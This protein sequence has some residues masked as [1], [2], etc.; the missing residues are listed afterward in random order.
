MITVSLSR[1]LWCLF[2]HPPSHP[3]GGHFHPHFTQGLRPYRGRD[4]ETRESW[5]AP[6]DI[7]FLL[8][9]T[10]KRSPV[11]T[12]VPTMHPS[13]RPPEGRHLPAGQGARTLTTQ[14]AVPQHPVIA[15]R[16]SLLRTARHLMSTCRP[17]G[18]CVQVEAAGAIMF[19]VL[20]VAT[21]ARGTGN[22]RL[23][24][25]GGFLCHSWEGRSSCSL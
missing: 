21:G 20:K 18:T 3:E 9:M 22:T 12:D 24:S 2:A 16:F 13:C 7:R 5:N 14:T 4:Q 25:R 11:R 17:P 6:S 8:E 19:T 1:L 23:L 10:A 15:T